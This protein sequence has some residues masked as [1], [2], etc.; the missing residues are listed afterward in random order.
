M[1]CDVCDNLPGH[2]WRRAE[3]RKDPLFQQCLSARCA[4]ASAFGPIQ[5]DPPRAALLALLRAL[6]TLENT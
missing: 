4:F 1:G 6:L 2:R 3:R 5:D